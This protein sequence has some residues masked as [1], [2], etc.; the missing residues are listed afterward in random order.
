LSDLRGRIGAATFGLLTV[1]TEEAAA[2]TNVFGLHQNLQGTNYFVAGPTS[3]KFEIVHSRIPHQTNIV[4]VQSAG[5]LI[6]DFRP[7]FLLLIGT[8]GGHSGRDHLQ[9]G[10]VV[11]ADYMDYAGYWKY[12]PG[13]ILERKLPH[14]HPSAHL[15]MNYVEP[16]RAKADPWID[17]ISV[18]RPVPGR[19]KLM[20]GGMVSANILLGDPENEE[21]KRILSH[22]DKAYAFEMEGHGVASAVYRARTSVHYN[23]QFLIVRGVSDLVDRDVEENQTTR[24]LWTPYAV[25]AAAVFALVLI[26]AF[27]KVGK[28]SV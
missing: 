3:S 12:A 6:E 5:A 24:Q 11:V 4:S 25:D 16:L 27:F 13:A 20:V 2:I 21:Q 10:D 9:V 8:A 28:I 22:F 19:P 17:R 1:T 14:D 18:P 26:E 7:E 23:P 15:L